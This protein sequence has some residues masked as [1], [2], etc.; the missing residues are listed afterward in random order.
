MYLTIV[1][2][3]EGH[4][5]IIDMRHGI[6][7][8][9]TNNIE[10]YP[11]RAI[12]WHPTNEMHYITGNDQGNMYLW[13]LRSQRRSVLKFKCYESY[14]SAPSHPHPVVGIRFF[15]NGNSILSVD[16]AGGI[17]NW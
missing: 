3:A 11:I 15:N 5:F 17:R 16:K 6:V 2:G 1:S 8:M 7:V 10:K 9:T 12:C 4:V 14:E 13:D